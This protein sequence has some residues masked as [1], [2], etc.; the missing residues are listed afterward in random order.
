MS[1]TVLAKATRNLNSR[2]R[3]TG[4]SA[5]ELWVKRDQNTGSS[6]QFE[7][8]QLSDVQY[9]MRLKSHESSAKYE[10]RN[11]KKVNLPNVKI[12]DRIYIKSDG[13]KSK[14]RD[15]YLVLSFVP[16][17]NEIEVQKILD[18]NRRNIVIVHLQN[19]YPVE[20]EDEDLHI[21]EQVECSVDEE[22][23]K[24]VKNQPKIDQTLQEKIETCPFCVKMKRKSINHHYNTCESILQI[25]PELRRK[26][27]KDYKDSDT[28]E[29]DDD[30]DDV[31]SHDIDISGENL[32]IF[33][34]DEF[35][36]QETLPDQ[37]ECTPSLLDTSDLDN[38]TSN[39]STGI[40]EDD[41]DEED[42][43]DSL[44]DNPSPP[45]S[46]GPAVVAQPQ[47]QIQ[48]LPVIP[49]ENSENEI[50]EDELSDEVIRNTVIQHDGC[51]ETNP[52]PN[53]RVRLGGRSLPGRPI[54]DRNLSADTPR[55]PRPPRSI[56]GRLVHAG[57]VIRYFT[58]Y[59]VDNQEFWLRATVQPMFLTVQRINPTY[60]NV[61]NERGEEVS[62]ELLGGIGG[63]QTL[64]GENWEFVG[65][66]ERRPVT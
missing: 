14:A 43:K 28:D 20:Y 59:M 23:T 13:S 34:G 46:P 5:R 7:D 63:W 39:E 26:R 45:R 3:H 4:C 51:C 36:P 52:E 38:D 9:Q 65:D 15:P 54:Q 10:S 18:K 40:Y 24:V 11:A 27:G 1:D 58:G 19:V 62:L 37:H 50:T 30:H 29:E 35:A 64:R 41:A 49:E 31:C 60:Y 21:D 61:L 48:I 47:N 16:N 6:L 17:K 32:M 8:Q 2:I 12:G 33:S 42:D 53:P 55:P 22:E 25:R 44:D 66:G 57:D 56:S